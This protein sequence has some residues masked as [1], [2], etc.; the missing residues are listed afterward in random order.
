MREHDKI[1][2]ENIDVSPQTSLTFPSSKF[3]QVNPCLDRIMDP[4]HAPS[5]PTLIIRSVNGSSSYILK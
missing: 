3:R 1:R 5:D 2:L 4:P